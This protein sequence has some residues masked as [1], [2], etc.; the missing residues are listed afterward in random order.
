M[1]AGVLPKGTA[2]AGYRIDGILGQGGMGVVYEATQLSLDRVVALK[3]LA[4]HLT[5]DIMF[6]QRFRREGQIQAGIDHPHI[7]TVFDS[8]QTEHGFFI[9]MRL[10]RGPTL[11]DLIVSRQLD[12]GRTLRILTPV[13]EALDTAHGAGLIHRDIKP[14]N[15]LVSGRD[16]AF[17]ADFGLTKASGDKS[18]TRT[19]QFV[20]TLDY[21]SPEQ[22]RGD[23]AAMQSDVYALAAVMYECLTGVVPFPKESE[24]AV[25]YAH[26]ADP[27]PRVS[28]HRPDLPGQLDEVMSKAMAKDP[29]V[30]PSSAGGLMLDVN[31]AFSRRMRAAFT[32]PGPI[33]VPEETGIRPAEME[34]GTR[35][36][37]QPE[38]DEVFPVEPTRAADPPAAPTSPAAPPPAEAVPP[39][40]PTAPGQATPAPPP[41]G[42]TT[43][44]APGDTFL[45]PGDTGPRETVPAAAQAQPAAPAPPAQPGRVVPPAAATPPSGP[46]PARPAAPR[47]RPPARRTTSPALVALGAL[48]VVVLAVVG[49]LVG[50]SGSGDEPSSDQQ[51]VASGPLAV[52]PPSSWRLVETEFNVPGLHLS[53]GTRLAPGGTPS[54]GV[55]EVGTTDAKTPTLLPASFVKRLDRAPPRD[56]P[57][58]L[59]D[60]EAYR[61][62][63][64]QVRGFNRRLNVYVAPTTE[65]VATIAC[66]APE[67]VAAAFMP[68]CESAAT[69]LELQSGDAYPLGADTAYSKK[70]NATMRKLNAARSNQT[71][72][73]RQAKT[74]RG[75]AQAAASLAGAYRSAAQA[76][77]STQVSPELATQ[78]ARVV[79]ALRQASAAYGQLAGAARKANKGAYRAATRDV[80]SAE[81]DLRRA[82]ASVGR[83]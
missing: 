26:M 16:H 37:E 6:Q 41:P 55:L 15:I 44:S 10:V 11:K 17:L 4:A 69:T 42:E 40:D 58:R 74:A 73:L 43:P 79:R 13:A 8:G 76:L 52:S 49:F 7:V 5:E 62:A 54:R 32:P 47:R 67:A 51:R 72:A 60:L 50:H 45:S 83:S 25:L 3:V 2:V 18:M 64:V 61:Y 24:A 30:R 33:E 14:Q 31:R 19:G 39:R 56:D 23:R 9:A 78:N 66:T 59:G 53:D 36:S 20:G 81:R 63:D 29:A 77:A 12:A 28:D 80:A 48:L 34:V 70:L 46:R 38:P 65:G 68:D 75:Q 35:E 57:V 82:L 27:P 71:R 1:A 22:I 21:I